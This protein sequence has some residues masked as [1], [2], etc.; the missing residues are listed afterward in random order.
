MIKIIFHNF[1]CQ[2]IS[3]SSFMSFH[4]LEQEIL[5]KYLDPNGLERGFL[6]ADLQK[7]LMSLNDENIEEICSKLINSSFVKDK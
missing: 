6:I 7:I 1:F 5:K 4:E 2:V 3:S